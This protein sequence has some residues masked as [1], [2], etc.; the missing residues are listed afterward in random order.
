MSGIEKNFFKYREQCNWNRSVSI[1]EKNS[2]NDEKFCFKERTSVLRI[3]I[4][5][6]GER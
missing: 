6:Q 1:K 5:F 2:A 3:E 4:T